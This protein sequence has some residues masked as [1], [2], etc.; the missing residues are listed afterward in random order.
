MGGLA[1]HCAMLLQ[2]G[3]DIDCRVLGSMGFVLANLANK[4]ACETL[5]THCRRAR[6]GAGALND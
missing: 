2:P 3:Q 1:T 6:A 5:Q 4:E